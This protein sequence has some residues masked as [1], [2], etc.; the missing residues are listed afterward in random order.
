MEKKEIMNT[1]YELKS[2]Y[3]RCF[4]EM[5][6]LQDRLDDLEQ[7]Y[8]DDLD[9]ANQQRGVAGNRLGYARE[10]IRMLKESQMDQKRVE[11][12]L[13]D[14]ISELESQLGLKNNTLSE[15]QEE[16]NKQKQEN[17]KLK[18]KN[19]YLTYIMNL[20]IFTR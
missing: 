16:I 18:G 4:K 15:Y 17:L 7:D 13:L 14:K 1:F 20:Y 3:G 8:D 19:F 5:E 2:E 10:E 9:Y 12:V 6:I 11:R